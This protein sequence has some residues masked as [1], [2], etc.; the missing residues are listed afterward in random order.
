MEVVTFTLIEDYE[1][2]NHSS[3]PPTV[4]HDLIMPRL[5]VFVSIVGRF[6]NTRYLSLPGTD[7]CASFVCYI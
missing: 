7:R 2:N 1:E 5:V 4:S 3:M 6:N